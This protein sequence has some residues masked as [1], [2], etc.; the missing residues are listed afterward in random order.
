MAA[1]SLALHLVGWITLLEIGAPQ[2]LSIGERALLVGAGLT[3]YLGGLRHACV[4]EHIA[5]VDIIRR[6]LT[7]NGKRPLT[8]GFCFSLGYSTTVFVLTTVVLIGVRTV[9]GCAVD[10]SS[11]LHEYQGLVGTVVCGVFSYLLASINM[12][13]VYGIVRTVV[14]TKRGP[15]NVSQLVRHAAGSVRSSWQAYPVG[16]LFGLRAPAGTQ[17]AL[18]VLAGIAVAV[19]LPSYAILCLPVLFA[20]GM[21]VERVNVSVL[22]QTWL[23]AG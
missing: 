8:A 18:L 13:L 17:V 16:V 14:Q 1:A 9:L 12:V 5:A 6:S 10:E 23:S 20:A 2:L 11:V 19:G 3:A 4:A 22:R 7:S 15:D 21:S